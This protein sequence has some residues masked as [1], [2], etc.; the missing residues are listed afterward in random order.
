MLRYD[1][2]L[3]QLPDC[4]EDHFEFRIVGDFQFAR[5]AL[6]VSIC[7]QHLAEVHER[8]HDFDI[9][10]RCALTAEHTGKH[11]AFKLCGWR[12]PSARELFRQ[13]A[14]RRRAW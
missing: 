10:Q 4:F 13:V 11:G 12:S 8:S 2:R 3:H 6:K 9:H 14:V 5:P 7:A 1:R